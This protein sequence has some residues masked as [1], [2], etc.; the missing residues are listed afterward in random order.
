MVT[1]DAVDLDTQDHVDDI[2][3]QHTI[4]TARTRSCDTITTAR[5]RSYDGVLSQTEL[6]QYLRQAAATEVEL[7]DEACDLLRAF[8]VASRRVRVCP[9]HG[10]DMPIRSLKAMYVVTVSYE[11]CGETYITHLI[12]G[13]HHIVWPVAHIQWLCY[14]A[15]YKQPW[16]RMILYTRVYATW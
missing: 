1:T 3:M 16:I 12:N 7:L 14:S 11:V 2:M 10:P 5:T 4:T 9:P 15:H 8:Y 6:R 13:G